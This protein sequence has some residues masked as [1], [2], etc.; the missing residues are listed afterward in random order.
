MLYA[1]FGILDKIVFPERKELMWLIRYG[2][3]CPIGIAFFF[4]TYKVKE[5]WLINTLT[6]R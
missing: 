4:L 6:P 5:E 2:I 3:L 1:V